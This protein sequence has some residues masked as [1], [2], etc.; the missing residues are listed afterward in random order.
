MPALGVWP[1]LGILAFVHQGLRQ[2]QRDMSVV[3]VLILPRDE[4]VDGLLPAIDPV[5]LAVDFDKAV[6][7]PTVR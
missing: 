7:D 6:E 3:E 5:R 1:G 2:I 4:L